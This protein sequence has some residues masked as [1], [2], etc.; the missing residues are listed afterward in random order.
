MHLFN[1]AVNC[2][3]IFKCHEAKA[4]VAV[5]V[6]LHHDLGVDDLAEAAKGVLKLALVRL[7]RQ[8]AHEDPTFFLALHRHRY[9]S[10]NGWRR[11]RQEQ[12]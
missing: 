3:P 6:S 1:S 9:C 2:P 8:A 7:P 11:E 12:D 5:S 10:A 4:P